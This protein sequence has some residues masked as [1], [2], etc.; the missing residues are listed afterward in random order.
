VRAAVTSA[1]REM[2]VVEAP[3]PRE[4]GT[5]EVVVRPEAVG[6]C[7]SDFHF[8]LGELDIFEGSP[9]PRVQ[10]HEVGA[11]IEALGPECREQL[12]VG[13]RVALHPLSS[14]G[15]CYPC[16][17]GRGNVCDNLSLIGIHEDGGLQELLRVPE[18]Q[19]FPIETGE[20]AVAALAE[21][22]SIGVRAVRRA[23]IREGERVVVL[24]AGPIG[25]AVQLVAR[26]H[27]ASA[28]LV[29][30]VRSRVELSGE[31]GAEAIAWTEPEEVVA[32]AREW[33]GGEGAPAVFDAT[34]TPS[35]I[36]AAVE[37]AASAGRVVVVGMSGEDVPLAVMSFTEKE[38]DVLGVSCCGGDEF[39]EAVEVV[40]RTSG[41][42]EG[43]ISHQFPLERAAEALEYA[44]E[45]PTEVMK[46][47]IRAPQ[48]SESIS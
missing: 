20:P 7:G 36:R 35:A 18:S 26:S 42:L 31:M 43:L 23:G 12:R 46:V 13:G 25:Q 39:A 10:G 24:G 32:T 45:N 16:S 34:G 14:C 8:Y 5:G 11:T 40:E 41:Q 27:G 21:P 15:R 2:E 33:A 47:V 22:V 28:L 19:V 1:I 3:E 44:M 4:P 17:V 48:S 30:P 9:F 37:I 6:I 38:L 29:D